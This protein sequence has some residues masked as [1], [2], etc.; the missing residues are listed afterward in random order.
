MKIMLRA[1][2]MALSFASIGTAYADGGDGGQAANTQFTEL[3]GIVAQVQVP[4]APAYAQNGQVQREQARTQ[5]SHGP[6]LFPP[7]S[8]YF[9]GAHS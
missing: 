6:W 5:S 8:N 1:G 7:L 3:P 2:L 9:P 4:N